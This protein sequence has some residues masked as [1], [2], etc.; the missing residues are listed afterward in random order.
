LSIGSRSQ[1]YAFIILAIW[2]PFSHEGNVLLGQ[3]A[4]PKFQVDPF[5]PKPLP[6]DWVT[7]NVGGTCVFSPVIDGVA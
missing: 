4:A 6:N 1:R 5:W 2:A 3:L 7:G